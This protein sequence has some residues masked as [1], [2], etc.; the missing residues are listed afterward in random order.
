[1]PFPTFSERVALFI[2]STL[3]GDAPLTAILGAPGRA[4]WYYQAPAEVPTGAY[5]TWANLTG[6]RER[7]GVT[8]PVF[9]LRIYSFDLAVCL[10]VESQLRVIFDRKVLTLSGGAKVT[11]Q[12]IDCSD[13]YDQYQKFAG[14]EAHL[15]VGGLTA[16][17]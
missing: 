2:Q 12:V 9:S 5:I 1:M 10:Q 16:T 8:E 4:Y 17:V 6:G 13:I 15:Q 3:D 11:T 14:R 7:G